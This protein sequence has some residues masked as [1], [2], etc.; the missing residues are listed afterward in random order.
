MLYKI[1][2]GGILKKVLCIGSVTTDVFVTPADSLPEP[3]TLR[4][5]DSV[6][7]Y[8]GGCAANASVD[9]FKLGVP[10]RLCCKVGRD[11]FGDF[12]ISSIKR[13]GMDASSIVVDDG[14]STTTSVVCINSS[15]E[16]S[17]LYNPGSTA[18]FTIDDVPDSIIE[19]CD[20][21]FVAGAMLMKEFDG[22]QCAE[23]LKKAQKLG[24]YTVMD[25]AWD[26]EDVWMPKV[27]ASLPYLDLFMPSRDEA[28]RLAKTDDPNKMADC[29]FSAGV[30]N[31]IIKLGSK[32]ALVCP[33]G[34]KRVVL[35]AYDSIKP[36]D[37][38]GAGDSFCAGFLAGLSM[39]WDFYKSGELAN[40]VGSHC[41]MEIGA[42]TGIK[43]IE[44]TIEFMKAHSNEQKGC[45]I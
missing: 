28:A 39:G 24:R 9:L 37:T 36:K 1:L 17:F 3:G 27:A 22:Q 21:V 26:Y 35:P 32:G 30:K 29:F 44:Q 43:S 25:T 6:L 19:E 13:L 7:T 10:V 18:A 15:G 16:R 20:I 41:V 23:L 2:R 12:V 5:V 11:S 38:T 8:V 14:V 33:S 31:V 34:G 42:S 4:A 45:K 40:A